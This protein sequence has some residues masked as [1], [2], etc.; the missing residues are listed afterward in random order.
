MAIKLNGSTSGSVA[1]DAPAD[2]SPSG[3]DVT[4]TLPTSAGSSGQYLQT[5]GS[6]TLSWQTV[7]SAAFESYALIN[8][9]K[10]SSDDGGTFT[11]GAWRTRDLNTELDDPDGIVSISSNQFTLGAGS[12]LIR[13]SA[14]AYRT[15]SHQTRLYDVTNTA[16]RA[17][18]GPGYA[19]ASNLGS[20]RSFGC[21]RVTITA[22][23]TYEIQHRCQTSSSTNG[24]GVGNSGGASWTDNVFAIVEIFKE[25]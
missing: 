17:S 18:G 1:L 7:A 14:P 12:Y 9:T 25:A 20:D 21:D 22:N 15:D 23:T 11:N 4:L 6:G 24:F 2:T 5:D 19:E 3:T 8:D 13:W 16:A 10:T